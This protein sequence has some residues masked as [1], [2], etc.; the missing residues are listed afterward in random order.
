MSQKKAKQKRS[1]TDS[2]DQWETLYPVEF[3]WVGDDV[4]VRR[5]DVVNE[6]WQQIDP[7]EIVWVP[8]RKR[9]KKL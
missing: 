7:S 2:E 3:K 9:R 4:Y 6:D 1:K 8:K 5:S